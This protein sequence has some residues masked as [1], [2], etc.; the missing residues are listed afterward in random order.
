[1]TTRNR[2]QLRFWM[3]LN[4]SDETEMFDFIQ[5]LGGDYGT[6]IKSLIKSDMDG[7]IDK[8]PD[9]LE[10]LKRKQILT[11]IKYKEV[12]TTY[13]QKKIS[14]MNIFGDEPSQSGL[15]AMKK[16]NE[17]QHGISSISIVDEKNHR[18][19]CPD[20][21]EKFV[22]A[23][24]NSEDI[25]KAKEMFLKHFYDNHGDSVPNKIVEELGQYA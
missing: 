11:N 8:N 15:R 7:D 13:L 18:L 24:G 20:C 9:S 25:L 2:K 5:S 3:N 1:M 16:G 14:Y 23:E 17:I 12:Q 10:S 6:Y 22:H 21:Q 4:D 19:V